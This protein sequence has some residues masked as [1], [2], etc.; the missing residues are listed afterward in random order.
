MEIFASAID[1]RYINAAIALIGGLVKKRTVHQNKFRKAVDLLIKN[2]DKCGAIMGALGLAIGIISIVD[3]NNDRGEVRRLQ[4]ELIDTF[5]KYPP[6]LWGQRLAEIRVGANALKRRQRTMG[7]MKFLAS[8]SLGYL[9]CASTVGVLAKTSLAIGS[10]AC[11]G[12]AVMNGVN[13]YN[14]HELIKRLD[15]DGHLS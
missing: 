3:S 5:K 2:Y 14:L 8:V 9:A 6:N 1:P 11:G 10:A 4:G 15:Q 7:A 12:A 13:Y